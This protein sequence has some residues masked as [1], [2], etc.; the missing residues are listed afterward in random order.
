[1]SIDPSLAQSVRMDFPPRYTGAR[2]LAFPRLFAVGMLVVGLAACGIAPD[3]GTSGERVGR[4]SDG[5]TAAGE[6]SPPSRPGLVD[7]RPLQGAGAVA[8]DPDRP[9]VAWAA[10]EEVRVSALGDGAEARHMPVGE[11]VGDVGFA[12]DGALWVVAGVPQLWRDGALA[13]RAD[14]VEADRLLAVD[15]QG[16]VVAGYTHSDGVGMLRRQV[17]LGPDCAVVGERLDPVPE[18][19]G[20]SEADPGAPLGR[21]TLRKVHAAADALA[22]RLSG[23]QLPAG[24]GI[25]R[26]I[27]ISGDGRWWVLE[28][29]QGRTLWR[30]E[31]RP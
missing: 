24:A 10:G 15:A 30:L 4:A 12:P 18:G 19:V 21:A 26:A 11:W 1:M 29:A 28:G 7:P 6:A 2:A 3:A 13:C 16:V 20:D 9:Q 22:Q 5:A 27:A 25:D 17:W 31:R 14:A 8:F 23:M